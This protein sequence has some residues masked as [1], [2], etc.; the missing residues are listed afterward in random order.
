M[1]THSF[2]FFIENVRRINPKGVCIGIMSDVEGTPTDETGYYPGQPCI[3]S[4]QC[5]SRKPRQEERVYLTGTIS[6]PQVIDV[7]GMDERF[8]TGKDDRG[9]LQRMP[10]SISAHIKHFFAQGCCCGLG[11]YHWERRRKHIVRRC[12]YRV[13]RNKT[14]QCPCFP[15][16]AVVIGPNHADRHAK[17]EHKHNA[18]D[19]DQANE[20]ANQ[21]VGRSGSLTATNTATGPDLS[22]LLPLLASGADF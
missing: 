4:Y 8:V 18:G 2:L 17:S 14:T 3:L 20:E 19:G 15:F 5:T 11:G 6:Q 9:G 12:Y 16:V 13:F 7:T 10:K 1:P 22:P 21:R